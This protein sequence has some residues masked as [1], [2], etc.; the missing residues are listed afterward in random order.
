MTDQDLIKRLHHH[1]NGDCD[2]TPV[3]STLLEAAYRIEELVKETVRLDAGWHE[4]NKEILRVALIAKE[5]EAKLAKAVEAL[6]EIAAEASVPVHTKKH[7]GIS[8]KKMYTAWRALAV[9]RIDH[10][11][12]MLAELE[13]K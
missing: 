8:N 3:C 9:K 2:M 6:R 10:A 1:A 11:R 4:A 13:G 5:A 12:A 7:G